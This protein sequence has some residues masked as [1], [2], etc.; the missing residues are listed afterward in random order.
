[1]SVFN[2]DFYLY[3]RN[4]NSALF[5]LHSFGK[6]YP[7]P[8]YII[9]RRENNETIIEC[10]LDGVGYFKSGST[11]TTLEKGDCYIIRPGGA[12]TYYSDDRN[13]YTKIWFSVSGSIVDDWLNFYKI[14]SPIFIRRLDITAY[15]NQIKKTA[16]GNFGFDSEKRLMLLT[17]NVLFEMGMT[18]PT[19][20]KSKQ[21]D[22]PYIKTTDNVILDIK[23]YIEKKCNETL[24]MKDVSLKFGI[25]QS[26]MNKLFTQ[27]YGV[28]P[29]K[30]HMKCKLNSAVY[31]L[32]STDMSVDMIGE[33]LGFYDRSHFRKAFSNEYGVTPGRYRRAFLNK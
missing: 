18:P 33:T 32:E 6:L 28:S 2:E 29:S 7:D 3:D 15:Y 9:S 4:R 1:M 10:V 25:S 17:H 22:A 11:V 24:N 13:P 16:L 14:D 26:V 12:H 30:Y 5:H 19:S 23:K 27:K 31:F 8:N 20:N 21:S